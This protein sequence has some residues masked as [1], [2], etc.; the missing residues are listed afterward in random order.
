MINFT[1]PQGHNFAKI[2]KH[3]SI[4][5]Y[6]IKSIIVFMISCTG[7]DQ[8]EKHLQFHAFYTNILVELKAEIKWE[9]V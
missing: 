1:R 8:P 6:S 2:S 7:L 5:S 9:M 4:S 3:K